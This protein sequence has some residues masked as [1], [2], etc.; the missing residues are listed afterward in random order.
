M[1]LLWA[2]NTCRWFAR[3]PIKGILL[4]ITVFFVCYPNPAMFWRHAARWRSPS[5]L[6]EPRHPSL[7][8]WVDE[9]QRALPSGASDRQIVRTVQ[10]F[11]YDRVAYAWDWDNWGVSDYLPTVEEVV[12][13]GREDC[14]GRAVAAASLMVR[15]GVQAQL[16]SDIAHVWVRTPVGDAMDPGQAPAIVSTDRGVVVR[17]GAL[18]NLGRASAFGVAVFPLIREAIVLAVLWV[19]LLHR[20]RRVVASLL[21]AAGLV[22]GLLALRAGSADYW[23]PIFSLQLAGVALMLGSVAFLL[24]RESRKRDRTGAREVASC[25]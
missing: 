11:V 7:Q 13:R 1:R 12:Q 8:P 20:D 24:R 14:D 21:G 19:L 4:G 16:V 15:F 2:L 9:L 5:S 17:W 25:A 22:G 23:K 3:I 10:Q 18:A 6:V